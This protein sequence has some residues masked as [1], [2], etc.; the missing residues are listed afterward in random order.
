[1]GKSKKHDSDRNKKRSSSSHHKH[2]SHKHHKNSH[3]ETHSKS[4]TK[5]HRHGGIATGS[6]LS[7]VS[8][9][10]TT[11]LLPHIT[12][13]VCSPKPSPTQPIQTLASTSS[14]SLNKTRVTKRSAMMPMSQ[15]E[16]LAEQSTIRKVYDQETG[17]TRTIRGSGEVIEEIVSRSQQKAINTASTASDGAVFM[18]GLTLL[19]QPSPKK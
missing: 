7:L 13:P 19:G 10:L 6:I 4:H 8:Q 14:Q 9:S 11:P 17:R 1:M 15:K 16:Y 12:P 2:T 5:S 18:H 3:E